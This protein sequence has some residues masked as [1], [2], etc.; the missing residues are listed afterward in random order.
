MLGQHRA[1]GHST[2]VGWEHGMQGALHDGKMG[3]GAEGR[4]CEWD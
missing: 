2:W 1:V 4:G 3:V